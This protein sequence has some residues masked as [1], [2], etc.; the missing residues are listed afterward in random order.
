[1][2][3]EVRSIPQQLGHQRRV[4]IKILA[5][6][7]LLAAAVPGPLDDLQREPVGQRQLPAPAQLARKRAAV[8]QHHART[9]AEPAHEQSTHRRNLPA[10]H[11]PDPGIVIVI[12]VANRIYR[13]AARRLGWSGTNPVS[14]RPKPSQG[15]R[16]RIFEGR[17]LEQTI[18]AAQEPYKTL[19]TLAALTGARLSELPALT[20]ANVRFDDLDDAEI[21]FGWQVGRHGKRQPTKTDGSAWTVPVPRELTVVLARHKLASGYAEP[22]DF[23]FATRTGRPLGQ[24]NVRRAQLGWQGTSQSLN[25]AMSPKHKLP[26][27]GPPLRKQS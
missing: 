25:T 12:G 5:R 1:M 17:E 26:R 27:R 4:G 11:P 15:K 14:E 20:W 22:S 9:D 18:R 7:D 10:A 3:D 16:R 23:V 2:P 6:A 13:H 19:F 21:E 8:Q 24:R